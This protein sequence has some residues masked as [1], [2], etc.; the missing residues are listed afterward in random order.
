M[1]VFQHLISVSV[2]TINEA[3]LE[4][5]TEKEV[6]VELSFFAKPGN[7]NPATLKESTAFHRGL[8]SG[9]SGRKSMHGAF[10]DLNPTTRDP[11]LQQV[12][13][14]RIRESLEIAAELGMTKVVFHPN[15]FPSTASDYQAYWID[16]QIVFWE[17]YAQILKESGITIYLENTRE[18]NAS[19]ILPIN[20][21]SKKSVI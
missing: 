7:L 13:D 12:C 14:F 15:Y 18:E 5:L 4:S 10:T 3:V 19:F 8:L 9:F 6:G 2:E 1:D 11:L 20:D 16:K 21:Y 17:K